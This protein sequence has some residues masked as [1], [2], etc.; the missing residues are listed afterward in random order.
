MLKAKPDPLLGHIRRLASLATPERRT[1][2]DLLCEFAA[3]RDEVAFTEL[4]RRHS[5]LVLSVC[6]HV[7]RQTQDAED[8]LQATFLV[9]ARRAGSIRKGEVLA[10]WLYGVAFR[11]AMKAK[12]QAA[13]RNPRGTR[14]VSIEKREPPNEAALRE[15]Q[16][17]LHEEIHRLPPKYRD[18]FVL[19]C[20]EGVSRKEA[21]EQLRWKEGTV[22]GRMAVARE[23]LRRRL[24]HRGVVLAAA[25]AA[26][27]LD[28][29]APPALAGATIAGDL[30]MIASTTAADIIRGT[31]STRVAALARPALG[32]TLLIKTATGVA[33]MAGLVAAGSAAVRTPGWTAHVTGTATSDATADNSSKGPLD[34]AINDN[35]GER[36]PPA[37]RK[38]LGTLR[39]RV[40]GLVYTCA[41]SP[42]GKVLAAGSADHGIG[43]F[44]S[45]TGTLLRE[46]HGHQTDVT[47][48]AFSADG[49]VLASGSADGQ[50]PTGRVRELGH[51]RS[52][53]G[54]GDRQNAS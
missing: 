51:N 17:I 21:A 3:H 19:C 20:L 4:V 23:Q 39:F 34:E 37:A 33:I 28:S 29:I 7:L 12:R 48:V 6:G 52:S 13:K 49:R 42:D 14:A 5:R 9:L 16:T 50:W 10:S 15:I 31:V 45:D 25:L 41:Y 38:R 2:S 11:I 30:T 27:A 32:G 53:V 46:L 8:A 24:A 36:L 26:V 44:A 18:P 1:D 40:G 22:A 54:L 43:L 35:S 47:C